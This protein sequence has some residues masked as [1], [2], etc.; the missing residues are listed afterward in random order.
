MAVQADFIIFGGAGRAENIE[1]YNRLVAIEHDLKSLNLLTH[2]EL[3]LFQESHELDPES[4]NS[5]T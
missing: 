4:G 3:L 2:K 1:K 5:S